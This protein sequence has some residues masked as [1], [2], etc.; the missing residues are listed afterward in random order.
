MDPQDRRRRLLPLAISMLS[1]LA[2]LAV[3]SFN[4]S[5]ASA[6]EQ[7]KGGKPTGSGDVAPSATQVIPGTPLR[8]TI[9]DNTQIDLRYSNPS[10]GMTNTQQF[11]G[12]DASGVD[13]WVNVGGT[14]RVFGPEYVPA[15]NTVNPYTPV[16]H[17]LS[18][19]GTPDNPWVVTTVN[20]VPGTTLRL[21]QR[22]SYVNGAEFMTLRYTLEQISGSAPMTATLFHAADLY[23]GGS[24]LGYGFYDSSTGGVGSYFTITTPT[25]QRPFYQQFVP[26]NPASAYKESYYSTIWD[27]IGSTTGPGDGFDNTILTFE[28]DAGAGLQWN[29]TVP[30]TGGVT[31]GDTDLFSVHS[32]TCGAFSDVHYGDFAYEHIYYLACRGI[33]GGYSDTT[34]RPNNL[35][36]RGQLSKIVAN[37]AGILDPIPTNRQTYRDVPPTHPFWVYIERLSARGIMG[38]YSDGTFRPDSNA[39]RGQIAKIVANA[40][41]IQDPIP[42]NRQTYTDVPP[43]HPFWV[44]IER[45]SGRG[46]IGGYSDGT[47]RPN[48]NATRAQT[49]KIAANTFFPGCCPPLRP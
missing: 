11:Y 2:V 7:G 48:N 40:A 26:N 3:L 33:I 49:A 31:V 10:L 17:T 23:T 1:M 6:Q 46:I 16:S 39:T 24:D 30:T 27:D 43:S 41:G 21:T 38:G 8:I 12:P 32:S 25:G 28:H 5:W 9:E 36:T 20:N 47:F 29:L 22:V 4:G 45:L 42:P 37:S 18:G 14:T 35:V 44:Y 13:L 19:S 15:G 34:F